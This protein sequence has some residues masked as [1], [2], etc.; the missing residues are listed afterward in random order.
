MDSD[1]THANGSQDRASS[2]VDFDSADKRRRLN[3]GRGPKMLRNRLK[4]KVF[5]VPSM[6]TMIGIFCAFLSIVKTFA[7]Q[8]TYASVCIGIAIIVDGLDGRVARRLNA[9]SAFGRE[10][11]SLS[12]VIAFGVAPAALMYSWAFSNAADEFGILVSFIYVV[13]GATRLARFNI[14]TSDSKGS[15]VGL[16][17]PGAAAALFCFVYMHPNPVSDPFLVGFFLA[18]TL[19]ISF[20]MVS[21]IP[22]FSVKHIRVGP[23]V[24]RRMLVLIAA[25]VA[26]AWYQHHLV[27]FLI[28]TAYAVSGPLEYMIRQKRLGWGKSTSEAKAEQAS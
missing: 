3:L 24:S 10:F 26:L 20:L 22:F 7:G 8:F 6:I 27:I 23:S 9:T 2:V 5:I 19:F 16:P 4:G 11:D 12:D 1:N 13:C 21:T 14:S 25:A 18:Y 17:I 15:F 28:S